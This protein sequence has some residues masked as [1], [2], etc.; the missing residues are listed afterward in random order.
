M[1]G[2]KPI[3]SEGN[4]WCQIHLTPFYTEAARQN[5]ISIDAGVLLIDNE[6]TVPPLPDKKN[7]HRNPVAVFVFGEPFSTQKRK[8][9]PRV[10]LVTSW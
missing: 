5:L 8:P 6:A 4:T 2:L 10:V 3:P 7:G 1:Q 9:A